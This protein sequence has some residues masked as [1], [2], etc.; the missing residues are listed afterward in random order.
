MYL[1]S[2]ASFSQARLRALIKPILPMHYL[3]LTPTLTSDLTLPL[4]YGYTTSRQHHQSNS[5]PGERGKRERRTC[6]RHIRTPG[7]SLTTAWQLWSFVCFFPLTGAPN[8]IW[9]L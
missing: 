4:R 5:I 2:R 6:I 1:G 3:S 8:V 7:S 9:L